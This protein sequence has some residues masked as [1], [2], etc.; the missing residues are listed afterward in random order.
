MRSL[1]GVGVG[2]IPQLKM[3][4]VQ[5]IA[6]WNLTSIIERGKFRNFTIFIASEIECRRPEASNIVR[7]SGVCSRKS[8]ER[9]NH[10][11]REQ[12]G[13]V[14]FQFTPLKGFIILISLESRPV[15]INLI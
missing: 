2:R 8:T 3:I 11:N 14:S 5:E 12:N 7:I 4:K 9:S 13:S 15:I 10:H 6:N 1:H